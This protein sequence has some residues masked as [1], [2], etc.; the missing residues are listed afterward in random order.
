MSND[1]NW[2]QFAQKWM[3]YVNDN[4]KNGNDP[5][6]LFLCYYMVLDRIITHYKGAS[7]VFQYYKQKMDLPMDAKNLP[8]RD[9]RI[10]A[11]FC[12]AWPREH[13]CL[14]TDL[15]DI[16]C[17][18][19]QPHNRDWVDKNRN[20]YDV[21]CGGIDRGPDCRNA[22]EAFMEIHKV[23]NSVFHGEDESVQKVQ[24]SI[25]V[26]EKLLELVT[27]PFDPGRDRQ[28]HSLQEFAEEWMYYL[29]LCTNNVNGADPFLQFLC[30]YMV[31]DRIIT[32][33]KRAER[34]VDDFKNTV[35]DKSSKEGKDWVKTDLRIATLLCDIWPEIHLYLERH[36]T[37]LEYLREPINLI[38]RTGKQVGVFEK[39]D[40]NLYDF[41]YKDSKSHTTSTNCQDVVTIFVKISKVRNHLY[42]G[43]KEAFNDRDYGLVRESVPIL[44]KF[45][46]TMIEHYDLQFNYHN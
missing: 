5:Y 19:Q 45:L 24:K 8:W 21:A 23:R 18:F 16:L 9:L 39:V 32:H 28:G 44:Q 41:A 46:N 36:L 43:E 13:S 22:I 4:K 38:N 33:Y 15:K 11:L 42:H 29:Y 12:A 6:L 37:G 10:A 31:F 7:K 27:N 2:I 40:D 17:N 35:K 26:L 25:P 30:F 1:G 34:I 3:Q 20:V 14:K